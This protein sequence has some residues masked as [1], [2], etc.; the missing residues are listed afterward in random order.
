MPISSLLKTQ[1]YPSRCPRLPAFND[2]LR[3]SYCASLVMTTNASIIQRKQNSLKDDSF[4]GHFK[5]T[6]WKV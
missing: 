6:I 4:S 5:V 3:N 2:F 1:H